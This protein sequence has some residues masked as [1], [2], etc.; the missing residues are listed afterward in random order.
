MVERPL[1]GRRAEGVVADREQAALLDQAWYRLSPGEVPTDAIAREALGA[2]L[3]A[4]LVESRMG[5]DSVDPELLSLLER[6]CE[7]NPLYLE[8]MLKYLADKGPASVR[9]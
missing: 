8:E 3:V 9:G 5:V 1:H 4:R 7:G 6:T 2:E